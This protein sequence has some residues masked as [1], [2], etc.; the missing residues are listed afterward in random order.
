MV[1]FLSVYSK[2]LNFTKKYSSKYLT[3]RQV[4]DLFIKICP[5]V[6]M[7]APIEAILVTLLST[8]KIFFS[9]ETKFW[10]T[11]SRVISQNLGSFQGKYLWRS[12]DLAEVHSNFSHDSEIYDF[13][14][15]YRGTF[16]T[17]WKI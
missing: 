15:L 6:I 8:L 16:R 10:R 5:D 9:I 12:S 14:K 1:Q 4:Q 11:P 3:T 13:T 17:H 2:N 7:K